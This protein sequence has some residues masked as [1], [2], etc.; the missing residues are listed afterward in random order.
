MPRIPYP[1]PEQLSPAAREAV[2]RSPI[3]VV[4]MMGG[5]SGA[6]F[7]GF[8]KF[9][10]AFYGGSSLPDDLREVAILRVGYLS[11]A[12]YE[13]FQHEPA[14]RLAGLSERQIDAIRQGGEH[15]EALSPVQQAILSFTDD[16]V[17]NVR[18]GD[19]TL[20]ALR[21][22]LRDVQL[23]DLTLLIG[24]YMTV[25]RFL[26]TTGVELDKAALDWKELSDAE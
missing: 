26:E 9:S 21:L 5:A 3:N 14:A 10:A 23:L 25:C 12:P 24:L 13:I 11:H 1:D 19:S 7:D 4:R 17:A 16:V 8:G 6:V 15:P 20:A 22:H 18:P 2:A